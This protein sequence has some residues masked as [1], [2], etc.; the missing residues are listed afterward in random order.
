[1]DKIREPAQPGMREK[2]ITGAQ[3][4]VRNMS[5]KKK[6]KLYVV[7]LCSCLSRLGCRLTH[8]S[9]ARASPLTRRLIRCSQRAVS[10]PTARY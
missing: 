5:M 10:S 4:Q 1:M 2:G 3:T 8:G 6:K 9:L 7:T